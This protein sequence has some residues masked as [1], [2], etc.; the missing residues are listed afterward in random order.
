MAKKAFYITVTFLSIF[1]ILFVYNLIRCYTRSPPADKPID[2]RGY[3]RELQ[4]TTAIEDD[5]VI[6]LSA[7]H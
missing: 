1:I 4:N 6:D 7:A 5:A 2:S 3:S